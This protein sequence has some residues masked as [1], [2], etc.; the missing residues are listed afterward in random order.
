MPPSLEPRCKA[1]SAKYMSKS[2]SQ[3]ITKHACEEAFATWHF[4][5]VLISLRVEVAG[6]F[7]FLVY[8]IILPLSKALFNLNLAHSILGK[9]DIARSFLIS[10]LSWFV[11]K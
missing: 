3:I 11:L 6:F 2:R 9:K 4:S 5:I 10:N 8:A 7:R 1:K